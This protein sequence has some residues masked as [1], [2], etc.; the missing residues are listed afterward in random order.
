MKI[1]FKKK[2]PIVIAIIFASI[3]GVVCAA[4]SIYD[5]ESWVLR[6]L[7]Q[8]SLLLTM[9]FHGVNC[10]VYHKQKVVG[11]FLWIVSGFLLFVMI[12]TV[13]VGLQKNVF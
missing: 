9:L 13:Y 7:T 12:F 4:L 6:I 11:S 10:F 2:R 5:G 3:L 8:G 1:E